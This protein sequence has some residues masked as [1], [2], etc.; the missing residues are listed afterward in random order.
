MNASEE[1]VVIKSA[2]ALGMVSTLVF[3]PVMCI[4]SLVGEKSEEGICLENLTFR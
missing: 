1:Q 4:S 3:L 2:W